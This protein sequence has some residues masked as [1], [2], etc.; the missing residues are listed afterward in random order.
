M[1]KQEFLET[2]RQGLSG[3]PKTEV[4]GRLSFYSE[5]IDDIVE[6]G[7]SE[8]AAVS[9]IGNVNEIISG[10]IADIPLTK[11]IKERITPRKKMGA[12]EIALLILG[13]PIWFSILIACLAVFISVYAVIWAVI[14]S[15]WAAEVSFAIG[16]LV[17]FALGIMSI[18]RGDG[19]RGIV[20][21]S[22]SSVLAGL[23]IL[24]FFGCRTATEGAIFLTKRIILWVKS[25]FQIKENG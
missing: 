17:S 22:A 1:N 25:L 23:S 19:V 15:L 5:L 12:F 16:V 21:M 7:K 10:I 8:E 11:I 24:L 13:F 3:Y 4:E 18:C 2:L 20:L 6:E 14:I 9:K